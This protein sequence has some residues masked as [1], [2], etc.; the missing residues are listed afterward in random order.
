ML[1]HELKDYLVYRNEMTGRVYQCHKG[2][3]ERWE[4]TNTVKHDTKL[5][6]NITLTEARQFCQL[7]RED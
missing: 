7:T 1:T 4:E 3:W 5:I 2:T 6:E